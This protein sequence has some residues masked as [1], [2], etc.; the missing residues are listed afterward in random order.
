MKFAQLPYL[1]FLAVIPALI[2]FYIYAARQKRKA[3]ERFAQ[4]NLWSGLLDSVSTRKGKIKRGLILS[5]LFFII[6]TLIQPQWGHHW[7]EIKRRGIDI[8]ICLDVSRS[9]LAE[10]VRPSRSERAKKEIESLIGTLKGDRVG[11]VAFA[12]TAFIQCPLT[13]DYATAKLFL[14]DIEPGIIPLGGTDI[15]KALK[16]GIEA[17]TG[18]ENKNK[19]IIL[20][21][22]GED[23][24]GQAAEAAEEAKKQNVAI[25]P[26]TVGLPEGA[27]IPITDEHG[28][29]TYIK[30]T[31]GRVVISK[32]DQNLLS[33]IAYTTGGKPGG[34][35][36][37][38]FSLEDIYIREIGKL[39]KDDL[40]STKRKRYHDKFQWPLGIAILLLA[41]ESMLTER[42]SGKR[43]QKT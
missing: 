43:A 20:I 40:G 12:G 10:D 7:E 4:Y 35:G 13:L 24:S 41:A 26:V 30:D 11:I 42:A 22:D 18:K 36:T 16:K 27:P 23:I 6:I 38:Q 8:I 34:I 5:G 17:F 19:A 3:A 25:Y 31:N 32:A 29:K 2:A 14:N 39:E 9:M 1:W 28:N 33:K 15:G 37:G 21:T